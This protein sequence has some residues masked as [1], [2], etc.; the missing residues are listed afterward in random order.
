MVVLH[1]LRTK[2]QMQSAKDQDNGEA[3][4][5]LL[6]APKGAGPHYYGPGTNAWRLFRGGDPRDLR[7]CLMHA[8]P[9]QSQTEVFPDQ[10]LVGDV[11]S[12]GKVR[13]VL[14]AL[15][16]CLAVFRTRTDFDVL[17][18]LGA[19]W[20]TIL[21]ALFARALGKP[22][23]IKVASEG[24]EVPSR[25]SMRYMPHRWFRVV[26]M[27]QM[28]VLI[29]ISATIESR[30]REAGLVQSRIRRIPN[31][32]DT[33][34]FSPFPQGRA[35]NEPI[36]VLFPGAVV[37]RKRPWLALEAVGRLQTEHSIEL[38]L[39]GPVEDEGLKRE[40]SEFADSIGLAGRVSW[41]GLVKDMP[42]LYR[43]VDIVCLPSE[44]EGM[45]NSILES[46]ASGIPYVITD[47]SSASEL[48]RS[49]GGLLSGD[50]PADLADSL[51]RALE[52]RLDLGSSGRRAAV[53]LFSREVI[54]GQYLLA[55]KHALAERGK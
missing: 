46:M 43:S 15:R 9:P 35:R 19:Y 30:L 32:V 50:D 6:W 8:Y 4:R 20:I 10:L 55:Y 29:A 31:G 47:F 2:S 21:P 39:A 12:G 23:V 45:P 28:T 22:T 49:G 24:L 13:Q 7:I 5:V 17:H 44:A 16:A 37:R 3:P 41:L 53:E 18:G 34:V 27:R 36:V 33:T 26:A 48:V 51:K 1:S 14:V 52:Q 42:S 40:L 54:L 25:A 38:W 11:G